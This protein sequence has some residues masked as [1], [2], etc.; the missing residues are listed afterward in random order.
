[1][2]EIEQTAERLRA[3]GQLDQVVESELQSLWKH[4]IQRVASSNLRRAMIHFIGKVAPVGFFVSPASSTGKNHPEWQCRRAD[5]TEQDE[6]LGAER[7]EMEQPKKWPN[8]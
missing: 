3:A 6:W 2:N 8:R 4:G 7:I 1:M 5:C